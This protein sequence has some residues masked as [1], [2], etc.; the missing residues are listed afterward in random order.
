[1]LIRSPLI[2]RAPRDRTARAGACGVAALSAVLA[3]ALVVPAL[4]SATPT[5]SF[6]AKIAPIPGFPH[7]GNCLGCG[8]DIE[9]EIGIAGTEYAGGPPPITQV[10]GYY[11]KGTKISSKGFTTCS[12]STLEQKGAAGCPKK[13]AAGP[14]G[15]T[16][17][18]VSLGGERVP[19]TV[20]VSPFL[21][22][23]GGLDFW[24]EGNSPV[25]IEKLAKGSW[26]YPASGPVI[27]VEVP[28]IETLPGAPDASAIRIKN[29]IGGAVKKGHK[30][31]YYGQV[32][33][34][35]PKGGFPAKIEVSFLGVP[36]PVVAETKVPCPPKKKH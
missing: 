24:I 19:E 32:P 31:T 13:S 26:S 35:C 3:T 34:S 33:N 21:A 7:T 11:P 9:V 15:S 2:Q 23:G 14:P 29:K 20:T 16:E 4:A 25:K 18:F 12:G 5:V 10:K 27:T 36:A 17:G 22:S 30:T 6:S 1:M 8:A 28:L